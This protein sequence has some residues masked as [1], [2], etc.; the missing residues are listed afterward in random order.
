MQN[1]TKKGSILAFTLIVVL[2]TLVAALGIL[3]VSNTEIKTSSATDKSA[4]SFQVADTGMEIVLDKLKNAVRID[5]TLSDVFPNCTEGSISGTVDGSA[6]KPYQVD[7]Y[8]SDDTLMA[9]NEEIK[10]VASMKSVGNYFNIKRA[11]NS[12]VCV[13]GWERIGANLRWGGMATSN[14]GEEVAAAVYGNQLYASSDGG[15]T[16]SPTATAENW[17]AVASSG[18]GLWLVAAE[19]A[20]LVYVSPDSGANW[21][22]YGANSSWTGVGISDDGQ[23]MGAVFGGNVIAGNI[24]FS[25][26]FGASWNTAP[27]GSTKRWYAIAF[28]AHGEKMA[29]VNQEGEI[30]VSSDG[31]ASWNS[32]MTAGGI[33][34]SVA[35]SDDGNRM[36]AIN[37][38][39][40]VYRSVDGG[41]N[42]NPTLANPGVANLSSVVMSANG[43]KVVTAVG[44]ATGV[45]ASGY[46]YIS[47]DGGDTWTM[48]NPAGAVRIWEHD[49]L[50]ISADGKRIFAG[51][52]NLTDAIWRYSE[53]D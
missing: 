6:D 40:I 19:R 26:D 18:D 48:H 49:S 31:G 27:I 17:D 8:K 37:S 47:D 38:A 46:I 33:L 13:S 15:D 10:E 43:M 24:Y 2:M 25:T 53:C 36:I 28:S 12:N 4:V 16:L 1:K 9:C 30:Y 29:A 41:D 5:R 50:A 14:S 20:G 32:E 3:T 39:G 45:G 7:F 21:T 51:T 34:T 22:T 23:Y 44:T 11:V 52:Y 35:V 42:W